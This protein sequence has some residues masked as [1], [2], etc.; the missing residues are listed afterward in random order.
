[1]WLP[2]TEPWTRVE[3]MSRQRPA[4][5]GIVT[6]DAF[7]VG[8]APEAVRIGL[9]VAESRDALT[10]GLRAVAEMLEQSPALSST[11]V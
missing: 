6:S 9:G 8:P 7:A 2:L 5:I 3:F 1:L 11:I 4:G 10:R